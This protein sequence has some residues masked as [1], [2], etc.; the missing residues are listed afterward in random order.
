MI[1][2]STDSGTLRK[3]DMDI[4]GKMASDYFGMSQDPEQIPATDDVKKWIIDNIPECLNIIRNDEKIVGYT[5]V[6][7]STREIARRFVSKQITEKTMF[8]EI[9]KLDIYGDVDAVYLCAAFLDEPYRG[10]GFVNQGLKKTLDIII[11]KSGRKPL[12]YM[13][14]WSEEGKKAGN[15]IAKNCGLELIE[16][17]D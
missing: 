9:K 8:E 1:K 6:L 2:F 11:N 7:P 15:R 13:W 14:A 17:E 5:F 16:R 4:I 10:K 3:K 12:L